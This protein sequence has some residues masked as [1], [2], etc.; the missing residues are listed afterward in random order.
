LE[1]AEETVLYTVTFRLTQRLG[2]GVIESNSGSADP[3]AF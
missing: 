1:D 3:R 2:V